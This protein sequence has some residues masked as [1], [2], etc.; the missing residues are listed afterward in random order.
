MVWTFRKTWHDKHYVY[1]QV[2]NFIMENS[3]GNAEALHGA[4]LK[5]L[6]AWIQNLGKSEMCFCTF[7]EVAWM[8]THTV[9]KYIRN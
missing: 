3:R 4:R 7:V 9:S 5:G 2:T 6:V 1:E 8:L